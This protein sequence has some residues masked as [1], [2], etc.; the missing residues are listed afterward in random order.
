MCL[1]SSL[2]VLRLALDQDLF[3]CSASGRRSVPI[4]NKFVNSISSVCRAWLRTWN[5]FL[6]FFFYCK[7]KF[8]FLK[9]KVRKNAFAS[10]IFFCSFSFQFSTP[11][12]AGESDSLECFVL[13]FVMPKPWRSHRNS[14]Q[15]Q[16]GHREHPTP[17]DCCHTPIEIEKKKN[18][19]FLFIWPFGLYKRYLQSNAWDP[20]D[21]SIITPHKNVSNDIFAW[22]SSLLQ[23]IAVIV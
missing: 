7:N 13:V 3:K 21:D 5:F 6:I 18:Y 20:L 19:I 23:H 17:R 4:F 22:F 16:L 11:F 10:E 9:K 15:V 14:R 8:H 1:Y 12:L 2:K